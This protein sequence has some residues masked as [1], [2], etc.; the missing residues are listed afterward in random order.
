MIC[1]V[2]SYPGANEVVARNYPTWRNAGFERI[3]GIGTIDGGCTWP[4]G[5]ES[6]TIG[7]NSYVNRDV[8]PRRLVDT[9]RYMTSL[10]G[11]DNA[12][13]IEYDVIMLKPFPAIPLGFSSPCKGGPQPWRLGQKFFHPPWVADRGSWDRILA[14]GEEC[15]RAGE[16]EGGSPDCFIG[17]VC[18]KHHIP[19]HENTFSTYSRNTIDNLAWMQEARQARLDGCHSIHGV[20]SRAAFDHILS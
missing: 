8:L 13:I 19:I 10:P 3:I 7:V 18:E 14:G 16:F 4:A 17:W 15:L 2:H 5:M 12:C 9:V 20:K 6:F 1:L 11:W